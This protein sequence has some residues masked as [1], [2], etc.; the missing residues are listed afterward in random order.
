MSMMQAQLAEATTRMA[1]AEEERNLALKLASKKTEDLVDLKGVGQPLVKFSGKSDQD[2][3][4]WQHK[5]K[6]FVKAKFGEDVERMLWSG[7]RSK[8]KSS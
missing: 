7:L 6:T 2:F 3:A 1:R 5:F 4:E 8:R